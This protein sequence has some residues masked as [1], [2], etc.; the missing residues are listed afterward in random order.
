L[1]SAIQSDPEL[2]ELP[3]RFWFSLDDGSADVSGL[4]ADTG[5]HVQP[6]GVA[7]LLAGRDTGIRLDPNDVVRTL[8]SVARRF[9]GLRG[10][11]WRV[12]E[13]ADPR[14]LL[15]DTTQAFPTAGPFPP[16]GPEC[17]WGC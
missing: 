6:D 3:G 10:N 4:A 2:A 9:V 17:R 5:V 11:A 1:D 16:G 7:L 14:I 15:D 13:L 12:K 8:I